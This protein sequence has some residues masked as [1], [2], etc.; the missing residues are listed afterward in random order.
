V[1]QTADILLRLP[2][3]PLGTVLFP[4]G[5]L[6]LRVFETR[7]MDMVRSCMRDSSAF[8]VCRI[9]DGGEVGQP[10]EHEPIGCLARI[11]DWDMT[12]PGVLQIRVIG[13]RR[14]R[15]S[16]RSIEKDGLIAA[17]VALIADD[18]LVSVP[19]DLE[20][21][22]G[23]LRKILIDLESKEANADERL[24]ASPYQFDSCAWVSNR[25]CELLYIPMSAKQKLMELNDPVA[26]LSLVQQFLQQRKVLE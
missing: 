3:F 17:E 25:L 12:Q 19:E 22:A 10:A 18:A 20:N 11:A 23:L 9:T 26:R 24:I 13:D 6:P 15:I 8:G 16:E 21:C 5:R 4:G 2:I 14:F 1:S 7:Y